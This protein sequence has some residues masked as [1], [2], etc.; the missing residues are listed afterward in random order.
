[1]ALLLAVIGT[2]DTG[3]VVAQVRA[4]L[5][6]TVTAI[7]AEANNTPD[8]VVRRKF[9]QKCATNLGSAAAGL[10]V[11]VI[12]QVGAANPTYTQLSQVTDAN[13]LTA[14]SAIFTQQAYA[15]ILP[16]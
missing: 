7:L 4:G 10:A 13:I 8:Y 14:L 11:A 16:S 12:T 5:Q 3:S 2:A 9:A 15:H 6:G 1:M